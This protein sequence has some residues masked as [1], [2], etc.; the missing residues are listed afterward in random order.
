MFIHES[1][2]SARPLFAFLFGVEIL[3]QNLFEYGGVRLGE[4]TSMMDEEGLYRPP[5]EFGGP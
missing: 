5:Q 4:Q 1:A 3:D 2:W